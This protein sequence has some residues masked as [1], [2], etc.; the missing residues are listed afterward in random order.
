MTHEDRGADP[1]RNPEVRQQLLGAVSRAADMLGTSP[2]AFRMDNVIQ[3]DDHVQ[4]YFSSQHG[5]TPPMKG[6]HVFRLHPGGETEYT[7]FNET[8]PLGSSYSFH[9]E[10][11]KFPQRRRHDTWQ[12]FRD[13]KWSGPE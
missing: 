2:E 13:G 12:V 5:T 1:R 4:A 6:D 8:T 7:H 9:P 10:K 3:H 11:T